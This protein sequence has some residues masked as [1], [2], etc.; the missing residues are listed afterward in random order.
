[1]GYEG[2][3]EV[4]DLGRVRSVTRIVSFG[5]QLRKVQGRILKPVVNRTGYLYVHFSARLGGHHVFIHRMVAGAFLPNPHNYPHV[6][7]KDEN[8]ANNT[9]RNL[10]W[11]TAKYNTNYGTGIRRR[12]L[13]QSRAVVQYDINMNKIKIHDGLQAAGRA[14]NIDA[15]TICSCCKGK[16]KYAGGFIWRYAQ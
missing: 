5:N 6:N 10:E 15:R 12:S 11:C 16:R 7:H 13:T 8:P 3:Y 4:S 14:T 9:L 2:L 1:M